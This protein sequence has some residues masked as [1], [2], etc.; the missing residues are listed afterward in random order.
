MNRVTLVGFM[1][2]NPTKVDTKSG[3]IMTKFKVSVKKK[4]KPKEGEPKYNYF[5]CVAFK[6]TA[7]YIYKYAN[8]QSKIAVSGSIDNY[9]Y[10]AQDGSKRY[11]TQILVDDA[12]IV[13]S[14]VNQGD[15]QQPQGDP[16]DQYQ[17]GSGF[18]EVTNDDELPF[19]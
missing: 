14:T 2:E 5:N 9:S 12:E 10:K 13:S 18:T 3:D 16:L 6:H 17:Q 15:F 19:L 7:D 1:V 8:S 4:G 11:G